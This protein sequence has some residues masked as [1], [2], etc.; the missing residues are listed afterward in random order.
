[1]KLGQKVGSIRETGLY[2]DKSQKRRQQ[3]EKIGFVWSLRAT[4]DTSIS[5]DQI[6]DALAVYRAEIKPSGPLTVPTE[7]TVPDSE[8]SPEST[9]GLP[10]GRS[11]KQLRSKAYLKENPGAEEKLRQIGFETHKKFFFTN[12]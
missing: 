8:P 5:F 3:L 1:M 6:Y 10:L 7:F 4:T 12:E 11:I 9:R 2:V